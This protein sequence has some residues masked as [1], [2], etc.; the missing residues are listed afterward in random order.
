LN[1]SSISVSEGQTIDL[2]GEII[3]QFDQ[4]INVSTVNENTVF[5]LDEYGAKVN[6]VYEIPDITTVKLI[7]TNLIPSTQYTL[8]IKQ[9]T[10]SQ[11][12]VKS[13]LEDSLPSDYTLSFVTREAVETDLVIDYDS[14]EVDISDKPIKIYSSN[15]GVVWDTK[16]FIK[17]NVLV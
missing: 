7:Y 4:I 6:V 2:S 15:N 14:Q 11:D 3:I 9:D 5:I 8:Y 1:V 12:G 17:D 16:Q 10:I 13:I